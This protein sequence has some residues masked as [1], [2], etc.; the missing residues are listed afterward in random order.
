MRRD[1]WGYMIRP[2]YVWVYTLYVYRIVARN[3][4]THWAVF[5]DCGMTDLVPLILQLRVMMSR[6]SSP[7]RLEYNTRRISGQ[8]KVNRHYKLAYLRQLVAHAGFHAE[9][10]LIFAPVPTSKVSTKGEADSRDVMR[11]HAAY[12]HTSISIPI[13]YDTTDPHS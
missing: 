2:S 11:I 6:V 13:H 8:H 5:A 10:D 12:T 3:T 1:G 9:L 7:V 4:I